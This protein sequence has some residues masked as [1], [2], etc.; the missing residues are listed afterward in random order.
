MKGLW[1]RALKGSTKYCF[2]FDSWLSLKKAS[3][4][5]AS[6]DV[7]L[8][9]MVKKIKVFC[10]AAIDN[11]TK[12]WPGGYYIVFSIKSMVPVERPLLAIGYKYNSR[13][14]LFFLLQQWRGALHWVFLIYRSILTNFL[15]SQ[16]TLLLTPFSCLSFLVQLMR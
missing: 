14:V 12:D 6:I 15:M 16:F 3:E 5:A 11:L 10:K 2:L 1:K 4:A 9:G 7:D 8:V 13:K